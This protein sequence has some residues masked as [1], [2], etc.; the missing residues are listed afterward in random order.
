MHK[1]IPSII[2]L[3]FFMLCLLC[4]P[5]HFATPDT[6]FFIWIFK[7]F[8]P[9][10]TIPKLN[11]SWTVKQEI[12]TLS[13]RYLSHQFCCRNLF[14]LYILHFQ[15]KSFAGCEIFEDFTWF[16]FMLR[17]TANSICFLCVGFD[18]TS[19]TWFVFML[20]TTTNCSIYFLGANWHSDGK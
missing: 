16:V 2:I 3:D 14:W 9:I 5:P 11:W 1:R 4:T 8:L 12:T 15:W 10:R 20:G 18:S 13:Y 17:T 7:N 19:F 6:H